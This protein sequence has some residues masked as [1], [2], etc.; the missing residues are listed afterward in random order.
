M[1]VSVRNAIAK[2]SGWICWASIITTFFMMILTTLD[3]LGRKLG[4]FN[5]NGSYEIIE[6]SMVIMT[7]MAIADLQV[8]DGHIK[9]DMV[10]MHLPFRFRKLLSALVLLAE[11][12]LY[13]MMAYVCFE[14][15]LEMIDTPLYTGILNLPYIPFYLVMIFGISVYVVLLFVE[16]VIDIISAVRNCDIKEQQVK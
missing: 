10:V 9:V 13:G 12:C 15:V 16:G 4:I 1:I 7:F 3:V 11:S 8:K 14:K 5:I 6:V 2:F